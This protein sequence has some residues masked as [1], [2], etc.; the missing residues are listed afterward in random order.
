MGGQQLTVRRDGRADWRA[1]TRTLSSTPELEGKVLG[2]SRQQ[3]LQP[4]GL[5]AALPGRGGGG[6]PDQQGTERAQSAAGAGAGGNE[7]S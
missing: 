5:R 4:G 3:V 2:V 6:G 7:C 1:V